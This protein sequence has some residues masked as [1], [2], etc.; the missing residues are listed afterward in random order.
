MHMNQLYLHM[1]VHNIS[2][3]SDLQLFLRPLPDEERLSASLF[4]LHHHQSKV[5][6]LA[7]VSTTVLGL[8]FPNLTPVW[9]PGRGKA[10]RHG[11]TLGRTSPEDTANNSPQKPQRIPT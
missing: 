5:F 3:L 10:H 8:A 6:D 9:L 7:L 2:N 11:A 1:Y 4:I